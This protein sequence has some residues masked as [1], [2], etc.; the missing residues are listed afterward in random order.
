MTWMGIPG[1]V[2][3]VFLVLAKWNINKM[4]RV[5]ALDKDIIFFSQRVIDILQIAH[6][7]SL[8]TPDVV[9]K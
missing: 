5:I 4:V 6:N 9:R 8:E 1:F 7:Q 3:F 2:F